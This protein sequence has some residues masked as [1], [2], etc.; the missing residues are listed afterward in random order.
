MLLAVLVLLLILVITMG[1]SN[2]QGKKE[3]EIWFIDPDDATLYRT[4]S[5]DEEMALPIL[6]NPAVKKFMCITEKEFDRIIE[7]RLEK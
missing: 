2:G 1:C 7:D 5:D 6:G 4:I 3:I